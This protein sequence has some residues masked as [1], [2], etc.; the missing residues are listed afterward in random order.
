MA[1]IDDLKYQIEDALERK[2]QA[3]RE[4]D[5]ARAE[6]E[7]LMETAQEGLAEANST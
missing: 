7:S 2:A 1:R 3:E 4:I 6:L 5:D